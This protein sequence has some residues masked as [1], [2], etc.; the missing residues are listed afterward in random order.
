[1]RTVLLALYTVLALHA[2]APAYADGVSVVTYTRLGHA[3]VFDADRRNAPGV[4]F[5]VRAE[6]AT[7]AVDV[8]FLNMVTGFHP[9]DEAQ[10]VTAGSLLKIEGLRFFSPRASSS[11]YLG[12]GVSWGFLSVGRAAPLAGG[13]SSW[14]GG[15]L[16]GEL[17]AGYELAR[18]SPVRVFVQADATAPF[19][20]AVS[21]TYAYPVGGFVRTGWDT[22]YMPTVVLSIG[23]GWHRGW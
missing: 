7:F 9:I 10:D 17:T 1:M 15:G 4:G 2:A 14:S 19:F 5:G 3:V 6:M 23:V 13:V 12:G 21:E 20:G 8:S 18:K 11:A 16:Q 22:R